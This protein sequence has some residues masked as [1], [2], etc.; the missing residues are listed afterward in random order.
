MNQENFSELENRASIS[1]EMDHV[2][3]MEARMR[4]QQEIELM[5][6]ERKVF[7][8]TDEEEQ[9]LLSFRRF[10]LRMRKQGE[11]FTWQT[12]KPDGVQIASDTA[13]IIHPSEVS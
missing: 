7:E 1:A 10:K 6:S 2:K 9:M 11:V 12:R 13:E 8:L 5:K 3:K 4:V